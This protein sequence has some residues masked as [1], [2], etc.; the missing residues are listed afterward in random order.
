MARRWTSQKVFHACLVVHCFVRSVAFG[1]LSFFSLVPSE[2]TPY[3]LLVF[4]FTFPEFVLLSTYCLLFLHWIEIY[5]FSHDQF[6]VSS[7][8]N[9]RRTYLTIFIVTSTVFYILLG[10]FYFLLALNDSVKV[11]IDDN[12]AATIETSIAVGCFTLVTIFTIIICYYAF[13]ALAGFPFSSAIASDRAKKISR[14][15]CVWSV[16]RIAKVKYAPLSLDLVRYFACI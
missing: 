11:N 3:A 9:L 5:V 8:R 12:W 13:I 6:E 14:V 16:G 10:L 7:P 2:D 4:L 1:T 15:F